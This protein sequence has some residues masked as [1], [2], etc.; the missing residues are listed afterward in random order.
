MAVSACS[1][2]SS[3]YYVRIRRRNGIGHFLYPLVFKTCGLAA[4]WLFPAMFE[5][6]GRHPKTPAKLLEHYR[7][8]H[9]VHGAVE[10]VLSDVGATRAESLKSFVGGIPTA[11]LYANG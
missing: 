9:T 8:M 4:F 3:G 2:F 1:R 7:T 10:A 11:S 5:K 6:S